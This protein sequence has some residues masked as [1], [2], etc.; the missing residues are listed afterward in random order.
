MYTW[1]KDFMCNTLVTGLCECM[2][3]ANDLIQRYLSYIKPNFRVI[4][5]EDQVK[6]INYIIIKLK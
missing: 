6:E 4:K 2:S 5:E 3:W 1:K